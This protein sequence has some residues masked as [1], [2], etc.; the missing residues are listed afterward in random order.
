M[1]RFVGLAQVEAH[2]RLDTR[3]PAGEPG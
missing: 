3:T 2:G 1:A